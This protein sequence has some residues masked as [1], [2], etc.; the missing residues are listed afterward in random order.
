MTLGGRAAQELVFNEVTTGAANDLEKVTHTAKQMIMRFGMSEKLGLRVLGRN[1]GH[2]L[3]GPRDGLRARL[4]RG[5]G[6]RHRRGD[7]PRDRGWS[8]ACAQRARGAHRGAAQVVGDPHRARDDRQGSV[9]A[10]AGRRE[11]GG[12]VPAGP[13]PTTPEGK[14][15]AADKRKR[16]PR[17][18]PFP[19]PGQ[20]MQ[21]PPPEGAQPWRA[22]FSSRFR[23][24]RYGSITNSAK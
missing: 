17:P 18:K 16:L 10:T 9:P 13:E 20:A 3:P 23:L 11:R 15:A 21:P 7:P 4:L 6:A 14:E 2:A 22:G 24:A 1:P 12:R 8:P 5:H 19:L